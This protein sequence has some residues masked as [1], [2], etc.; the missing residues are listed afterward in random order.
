MDL[1]MHHINNSLRLHPDQP[2]MVR[3]REKITGERARINEKSLMDRVL[4]KE[5]MQTPEVASAPTDEAW[6]T[7]SPAP[8]VMP[9]D[10]SSSSDPN[11]VS[12]G[13]D[14]HQPSNEPTSNP[15]LS[16]TDEQ[17]IWQG[18]YTPADQVGSMSP[19]Q[20]RFY[21][22]Y[23]TGLFSSLG[24]PEVAAQFDDSQNAF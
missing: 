3:L 12:S 20:E 2:E 13:Q 21:Q 16:M 10:Q 5:M 15:D 8:S 4:H 1:A 19:A 11:D 9:D 22:E 18:K 24:M 6:Y 17:G 14:N 23:L 7:S